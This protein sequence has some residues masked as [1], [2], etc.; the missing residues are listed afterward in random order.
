MSWSIEERE[1]IE[2]MTSLPE[3]FKDITSGRVRQYKDIIIISYRSAEL[4]NVFKFL[5]RHYG[6]LKKLGIKYIVHHYGTELVPLVDNTIY[7]F[8]S[9]YSD[10]VKPHINI[11]LPKE[12]YRASAD[13]DFV[14]YLGN[15]CI[16][17]G[18]RG[19]PFFAYDPRH[20]TYVVADITHHYIP[21]ISESLWDFIVGLMKKMN[22]MK[23]DPHKIIDELMKENILWSRY[24][25]LQDIIADLIYMDIEKYEN[26]VLLPLEYS[27][28]D[29]TI[30]ITPT[31]VKIIGKAKAHRKGLE[32]T[33][34]AEYP[35]ELEDL[36]YNVEVEAELEYKPTIKGDEIILLLMSTKGKGYIIINGEKLWHPNISKETYEICTGEVHLPHEIKIEK[37]L[38]TEL[39]YKSHIMEL[40]ASL[41]N[42]FLDNDASNYGYELWK[43]I[44]DNITPLYPEDWE[45]EDWEDEEEEEDW[46]EE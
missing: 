25:A 26:P 19:K 35:K 42:P 6:T 45:D 23:E 28:G 34:V 2:I 5:D 4:E 40:L 29:I 32:T 39:K 12:W 16:V 46:E 36:E 11:A 18:D 41:T 38:L 15:D 9:P 8:C 44:N 22:G 24:S 31:T 37:N 33:F 30:K 10:H 1:T 43:Y 13:M 3:P 14:G 7:I 20:N 27:D 21:D 17:I